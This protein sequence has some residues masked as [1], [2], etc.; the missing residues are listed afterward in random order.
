MGNRVD[1]FRAGRLPTATGAAE[2]GA[3][4]MVSRRFGLVGFAAAL[5]A[6]G[7]SASD[8]LV[9]GVPLP[10]DVAVQPVPDG[11]SG[12]AGSF[13]GAWVG[14]WDGAMRHVLVVE[15]VRRDQMAQVLSRSPTRRRATSGACGFGGGRPSPTAR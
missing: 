12:P 6:C 7:A 2:K 14:S 4:V 11:V 8:R 3:A 13:S 10:D 9:G 1:R 5:I 15:A